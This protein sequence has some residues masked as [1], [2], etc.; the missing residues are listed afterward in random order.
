MRVPLGEHG[1]MGGEVNLFQH[2]RMC[3][4]ELCCTHLCF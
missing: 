1:P 2:L 3:L 4:V